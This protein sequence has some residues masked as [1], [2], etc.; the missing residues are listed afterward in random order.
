MGHGVVST[1]LPLVLLLHSIS[2]ALC[3]AHCSECYLVF[4]SPTALSVRVGLLKCFL[5]GS[6]IGCSPHTRFYAADNGNDQYMIILYLFYSEK[7]SEENL[8]KHFL[9]NLE[10]N[11]AIFNYLNH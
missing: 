3:P 6:F 11:L 9:V 2:L 1:R 10:N 4:V 7:L 8:K 5:T